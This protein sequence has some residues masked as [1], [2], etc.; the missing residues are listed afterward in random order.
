M[1]NMHKYVVQ[2]V[3]ATYLR[4]KWMAYCVYQNKQK[5]I[6]WSR[7]LCQVILSGS[8]SRRTKRWISSSVNSAG[9]V[10]VIP[11]FYSTCK[12]N[13]FLILKKLDQLKR[14][15]NCL[16]YSQKNR[17]NYSLFGEASTTV[18]TSSGESTVRKNDG[19]LKCHWK[20]WANTTAVLGLIWMVNR[21]LVMSPTGNKQ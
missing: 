1:L 15:I 3:S 10:F 6:K 8:I 14:S 19:L 7:P 16:N 13:G 17:N 21:F 20:L 11:S 2:W 9:E 5:T 18:A 12:W 4:C